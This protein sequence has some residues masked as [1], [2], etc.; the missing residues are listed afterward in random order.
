M[1]NRLPV[2]YARRGFTLVELLV[3]IG[4]I[5]VLIAILLPALQAAR[6]QAAMVTCSSNLRQV[7]I[8]L[9]QYITANREK[10]P[11][12]YYLTSVSPGGWLWSNELMRGKYLSGAY[13]QL[14]NRAENQKTPFL[15]PAAGID[16][17]P[18]AG[19]VYADA[20]MP[21]SNGLNNQ[22]R[23]HSYPDADSRVATQYMLNAR[24]AGTGNRASDVFASPFC[25][26]GSTAALNNPIYTRMRSKIR[27]SSET[28]M[29]FEGNSEHL[30]VASRLAA[31]HGKPG[32]RNGMTNILFFDGHVTAFTTEPYDRADVRLGA[33]TGAGPTQF[34]G[35][36][37]EN[38]GESRTRFFIRE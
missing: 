17:Q 20:L 1:R 2:A 27:N 26:F 36:K 6:R 22:Y 30:V 29:V 34:A 14:G 25:T 32:E 37:L 7:G 13:G 23:W 12:Q 18:G 38:H 28:V 21:P 15:C 5:A 9:M 35:F 3:V 31:R 19:A 33:T 4:I 11:P 8:G 10:H 24:S 16:A